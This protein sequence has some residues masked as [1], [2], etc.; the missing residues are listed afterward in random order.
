VLLAINRAELVERAQRCYDDEIRQ[1]DMAPG[2]RIYTGATIDN[3]DH[4]R[5]TRTRAPLNPARAASADSSS[6]FNAAA[7]EIC[8]SLMVMSC[9]PNSQRV[10][11]R[12]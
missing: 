5:C 8:P 2:S 6:F 3:R 9:Q 7:T 12:K 4:G 1:R 10:L 11:G